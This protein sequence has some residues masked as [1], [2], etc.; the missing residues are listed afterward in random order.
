[1]KTVRVELGERTYPIH[2]GAGLLGNTELYKPHIKGAK[3][4]I[5][6]NETVASLCLDKVESALAPIAEVHP[7]ILPDGESHKRLST[8]ESIVDQMLSVPCDRKTT[9]V[10]LGGG[11][12]G[13]IAGFTAACYQR[14]IR[15]IQVPTTLLAQVDS[16]VG[17]KTG[18]NH[19]L[20]KNM[21]GAFHQPVCVIADSEI[22]TSLPEREFC[23]G[24][25]EVIK[26]GLIRDRDFFEWLE[27]NIELLL[28]R[29]SNA[30]A[31]AVEQSCRNKATVVAE[32][33]TES[34]IRAI[35]NF[36]HTFGHA[37]ETGLNYKEWLHGEAVAAGMVMAGELSVRLG[38]LSNQENQ[39]IKPLLK[40]AKL[41]ISPPRHLN[42]KEFK[43]IMAVDKKAESGTVKFIVLNQLG[44]AQVTSDYDNEILES[45]LASFLG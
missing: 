25:A 44:D 27:N 4:F 28:Q 23:A 12:V 39:R 33:E 42:A 15:F 24:L 40:K 3:V 43:S 9:V 8:I 1:M 11:V 38:L 6:T 19:P 41:P 13:D 30:V 7:S 35:L 18:V 31:Y 2:I 21:I 16:S 45:T 10:A 5:I 26:Y 34:G 36:G 37:I 17:G 32:D 22:L 29:E 20:G 14:G